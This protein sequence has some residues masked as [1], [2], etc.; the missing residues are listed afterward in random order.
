MN[1]RTSHAVLAIAAVAALLLLAGEA[2]VPLLYNAAN[3]S[4]AAHVDPATVPKSLGKDAD[5]LVPLMD[6]LLGETGTLTLNIKL[7]DYESAER[8]LA[9]YTELSAKFDRLVINLDVSGTDIGEFQRN[10]QQNLATLTALLNDTQ[11]FD[12]LQRVEID[13]Q[14][15]EGQHAAVIYEGEALQQKMQEG[16]SAYASREN[17]TTRIAGRY[18]VNATPYQESVRNYAEIADASKGRQEGASGS[19]TS[20]LGIAVTPDTGR[21]G[22]TLSITGTYTG[23]TAETPI[24]VYIDSQIAGNATLDASG[25]YACSYQ[26]NRTPAGL[27]LAYATAGEVYSTVAAFEVLP[28]ENSITLALAEMS[29]TAVTC[30]GNLTTTGGRPVTGAPVVLRVDGTTLI[31]IETDGNGTYR[32]ELTLPAGEHTVRAEFHAAGYPLNASE[33]P[34]ETVV[35]RNE[36]LSPLPFVAAIAAALGSGWY[37]RRRHRPGEITP[38]PEPTEAVNPDEEAATTPPQ[39]EIAGLPPR[40]VATVLF[41]V[42]RARL[43]LP[44]TKT[45]RDCARLSPAHAG[46]F[47]RYELIRYA[48]ETPSEEELRAMERVA[49]GG[50]DDTA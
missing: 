11:R 12:D 43:G 8:D 36:G 26:I 46:F 31:G 30:T 16:F 50:E 41:R 21:Y 6:D 7:E 22:D 45:P 38:V 37:L 47:E 40:D 15:D 42:L 35:I 23:G 13:V 14:G 39:V 2:A 25:N 4:T 24:E 48:G 27:H 44:D 33:S 9:R 20:P 29:G 5:A 18:G 32:E 10:N 49:L 34:V 19:A 17:A 28:G 1:S 3:T